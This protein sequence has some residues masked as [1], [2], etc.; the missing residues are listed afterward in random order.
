MSKNGKDPGTRYALMS[1]TMA[2]KGASAHPLG[3]PYIG[4]TVEAASA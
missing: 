1:S 4:R 2:S 3:D